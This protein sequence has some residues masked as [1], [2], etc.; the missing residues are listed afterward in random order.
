MLEKQRVSIPGLSFDFDSFLFLFSF[1]FSIIFRLFFIFIFAAIHEALKARDAKSS[2]R[3]SYHVGSD[4]LDQ[5]FICDD[6]FLIY[7]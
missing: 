2:G 7:C 6:F 5:F 4:F 3:T 1:F